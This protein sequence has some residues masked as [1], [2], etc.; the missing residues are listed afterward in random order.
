MFWLS[1][2]LPGYRG[3]PSSPSVSAPN[4]PIGSPSQIRSL[5]QVRGLL[6]QAWHCRYSNSSQAA[7]VN[8]VYPQRTIS[9]WTMIAKNSILQYCGKNNLIN[10][11]W[12]G[13]VNLPPMKIYQKVMVFFGGGWS[14]RHLHQFLGPI[15]LSWTLLCWPPPPKRTPT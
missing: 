12:L 15:Q 4:W 9:I 6:I 1:L 3:P 14:H 8:V 7:C 10:Q 2:R 13:M 5:G 11:P